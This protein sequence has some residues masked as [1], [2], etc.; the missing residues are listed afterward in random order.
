MSVFLYSPWGQRPGPVMFASEFAALGGCL[1][2]PRGSISICWMDFFSLTI[3]TGRPPGR[4]PRRAGNHWSPR[5]WRGLHLGSQDSH[6]N[7][8]ANIQIFCWLVRQNSGE[9]KCCLH[10]DPSERERGGHLWVSKDAG[11]QPP[12]VEESK[13]RQSGL[14]GEL[15]VPSLSAGY[16]LSWVPCDLHSWDCLRIVTAVPAISATFWAGRR[17]P[18]EEQ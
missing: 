6:W 16:S 18:W 17:K 8:C 3:Q 4:E 10:I 9:Y 7:V 15:K 13:G 1:I 5:F 14:V 2:Q 11:S 12:L